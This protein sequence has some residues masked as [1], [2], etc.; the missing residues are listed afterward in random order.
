[1]T[2]LLA[3]VK[4]ALRRRS[5]GEVSVGDAIE[6]TKSERSAVSRHSTPGTITHEKTSST[7]FKA[8]SSSSSQ[9]MNILFK[10]LTHRGFMVC[11]S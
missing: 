11:V 4:T 3:S 10:A 6:L 9:R 1:M 5:S 8:S 2:G 7:S